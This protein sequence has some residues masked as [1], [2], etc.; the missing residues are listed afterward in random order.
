MTA[1]GI[2]LSRPP[3][4]SESGLDVVEVDPLSDPRWEAFVAT[5]PD[6]L[7]YHHRGWLEALARGYGHSPLALACEAEGGV[8][9]GVLPLCEARGLLSG[10]RLVSLPHTPVAGALTTAPAV[11][12]ALLEAAIRR[13][14]ATR[15]SSLQIKA[16][17]EQ[18][19][20]LPH[21][22]VGR[23]WS[24]TYLLELPD[25][26]EELRFGSSRNHNR[27]RWAMNKARREGVTARDASSQDDLGAWYRIYLETMRSH[28]VPPR[29][30]SF[31]EALWTSLRPSGLMRLLLAE[32]R[33]AGAT[34]LL[35]GS[36]FL[37]SGA[38]MFYAFNGCRRRDFHLRPN[39][40]IQWCAL[41]DAHAA[42][43]RWYD[44]GEVEQHQEGLATFKHKWGGRPR[45]L[46]RYYFPSPREL[47]GGIL[48][49]GSRSRALVSAAWRR[50]PLDVTAR[51]GELLYRHL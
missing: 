12:R 43:L 30:Y 23:A 20:G 9:K 8:L 46:H 34:R 22:M 4:R 49:E 33:E 2:A 17:L 6:R 25:R 5:R 44:F 36:I 10:R 7:V 21:G 45:P 18:L 13:V 32:R 24:E 27:L 37:S 3:H 29:P 39:Y 28:A 1:E 16:G 19:E 47:E 41:H 40:L 26:S 35:A 51:A 15:A 50:L 14:R 48:R 31:F 42:G 11:T 38:T